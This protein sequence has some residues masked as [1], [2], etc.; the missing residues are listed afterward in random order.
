LQAEPADEHSAG[1]LSVSPNERIPSLD[2][3]RGIAVMGILLANLP[4][5]A[6]PEAA[7]FSPLPAGGT[8]LAD[9]AAWYLNFVLVEGRMRGLF[10]FLFGASLLLVVTRAH[11][12]GLSELAV[13]FRRMAA[14]FAIGM[15]HL[16]LI[17]WGDILTHY[18]LVG[19]A[20]FLFTRSDTR[21]LIVWA[22]GFL[23]LGLLY[24]LGGYG[25][26]L[27]SAPRATGQQIATWTE[28]S[29]AFGVPPAADVRA[30]IAAMRGGWLDQVRWRWAH[31]HNPFQFVLLIGPQTLSAMLFG[32]AAYRSG[33]LTGEWDRP[34]LKTWAI[35]GICLSL[36]AYALL[37]LDTLA[38][39]FDQRS[40]YFG[41]IVASE[42]FRMIGVV[43]YAA[44]FILLMRP[45][46]WLTTRLAAVGRAAFSN[47]LG[48]SLLVTAVF[49]G[50]GLGQFAHIS[51]AT[52]YFVAV[53]VWIIMLSWS[54]PW[55][56]RFAFGPL[57]WLWR[58]VARGQLQPLRRPVP[59]L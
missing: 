52:I 37:G 12:A 30:E 57:E 50:W 4:A 39:G 1:A 58:S 29:R 51:R 13:H 21:T 40:V 15:V 18:A 56:D 53:A 10:S 45:G 24:D 28:F 6:F 41:S 22:C 11:A 31:A 27:D 44:L 17:W 23:L 25:A 26:L 46:G 3:I 2:V 48:T 55:L 8:A 32:M 36:P 38:S 34:R 7:Y 19:L 5:F 33:M 59:A 43:G 16:Y 49:Y 35:I 20:A 14:L 9:R 47:Y 54:K 42:P